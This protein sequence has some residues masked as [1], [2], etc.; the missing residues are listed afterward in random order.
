MFI[1]RRLELQTIHMCISTQLQQRDLSGTSKGELKGMAHEVMRAQHD[2]KPH[3]C[4]RAR[5]AENRVSFYMTQKPSLGGLDL[6]GLHQPFN[7]KDFSNIKLYITLFFLDIKI[8]KFHGHW[9]LI[10]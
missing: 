1:K 9:R 10:F 3:Y 2:F 8:N 4:N 7:L 6:L 5:T